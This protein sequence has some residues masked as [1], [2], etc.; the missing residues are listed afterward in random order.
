MSV[1]QY[2]KKIRKGLSEHSAFSVCTVLEIL[3]DYLYIDEEEKS[4]IEVEEVFQ[5]IDLL[6]DFLKDALCSR[7]CKE[8]ICECIKKN[9]DLLLKQ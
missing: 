7:G 6:E 1:Y 4:Y 9:K 8:R 3:H 5:L 2:Y